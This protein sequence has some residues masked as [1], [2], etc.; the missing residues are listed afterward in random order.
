MK[1]VII[2]AGVNALTS[3]LLLQ[4]HGVDVHIVAQN[5]LCKTTSTIAGALWE[6]P[7]AVCGFFQHVSETAVLREKSWAIASYREFQ[8]L[9]LNRRTGVFMRP[10]N[11]YLKENLHENLHELQKFRELSACADGLIHDSTLAQNQQNS[12]YIDAYRYIAPQIDTDTYLAYLYEEFLNCGGAIHCKTVISLTRDLD[13]LCDQL[14]PDVVINCAGLGARDIASDQQVLPVRGAWFSILNDGTYFPKVDQAHCTSLEALSSDGAFMF[15]L[16]RGENHLVVGGIAQPHQWDTHLTRT[17][18]A[19][20]RMLN[21]CFE[22][23]PMLRQADFATAD[24]RVGLRPFRIGGVRLDLDGQSYSLPVISNYGHGGAGVLLSWGC[25]QEVLQ[26]VIQL[27]NQRAY[28]A[29]APAN[30]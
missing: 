4:R 21:L 9:A 18:P 26:L 16:P 23:F 22:S 29:V 13:A 8:K 15:I 14:E 17:S 12:D 19:V 11:F 20:S 7:P 24:F 1:A 10:V 2:G 6:M 25:A 30:S 28:L 5:F 27:A 3:A